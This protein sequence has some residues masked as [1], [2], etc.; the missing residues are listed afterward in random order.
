MKNG[1]QVPTGAN[2]YLFFNHAFGFTYAI[3]S[4]SNRYLDG[5]VLE[6]TTDNGETWK[7]AK[8]L[9]DAGENYTGTLY[10]ETFTGYNPLRNRAGFVG[11]SHGYVSTR[12]NLS[13]L[14]GKTVNF[15]WRMGTDYEYSFLGWVVDDVTFYQCVG[16]PAVPALSAPSNGSLVSTYHPKLDW[17]DA[18]N[19]SSYQLELATDSGF[20]NL[21][22]PDQCY[23][24]SSF[25]AYTKDLAANTRYYWHVKAA[26][27]IGRSKRLVANLV[28]PD[29]P[30]NTALERA[31]QRFH[32]AQPA[33]HL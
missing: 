21:V 20:T 1:V 26:N 7:D 27:S 22:E 4:G 3:V 14:A 6:Y 31:G 2:T 5:A 18:A 12:Y 10:N 15:R 23:P 30:G 32:P 11:E 16:N 8:P 29:A 17:G 19:A 28:I 25:Q 24:A 9:F 13:S 33:S